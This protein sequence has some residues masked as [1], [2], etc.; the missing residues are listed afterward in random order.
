MRVDWQAAAAK[1]SRARSPSRK[2]INGRFS[3]GHAALCC[4][5]GSPAAVESAAAVVSRLSASEDLKI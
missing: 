4:D 2:R 5:A 3:H 1:R